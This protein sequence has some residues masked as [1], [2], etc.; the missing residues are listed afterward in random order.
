VVILTIVFSMLFSSWRMI[1]G[2]QRAQKECLETNLTY[3]RGPYPGVC[4]TMFF[5]LRVSS[6]PS[7]SPPAGPGSVSSIG[8]PTPS[9]P[10]TLEPLPY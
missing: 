10:P 5:L 2:R 1:W 6:C 7:L 4:G 9:L 3:A 8:V